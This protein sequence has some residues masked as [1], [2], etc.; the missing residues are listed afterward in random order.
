MLCMVLCGSIAAWRAFNLDPVYEAET[1]LYVGKKTDAEGV[2]YTDL[3][4]GASVVLDYQE[5]AKSRIV[6]STAIQEL[7][8]TEFSVDELSKLISVNQRP[9]TRV[10]EI[11]VIDTDPEMAMVLTNK[12]AD[13][14]KRKIAEIMQVENV[15]VIDA[16]ELPERP[17]S[18]SKR[19]V[20]VI[21]ILIGAVLGVGI[22]FLMAYLDNTVKTSD[23]VKKHLNL[24]VIGTIPAFKAEEKGAELF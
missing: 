2:S 13:V 7:G 18:P 24:P 11:T 14:F 16:A 12:V 8:L 6:A 21:G 4:I 3:N 20:T 23:D 5:I 1:T 15:Q 17:I 19:L 22:V 10:I 9:D